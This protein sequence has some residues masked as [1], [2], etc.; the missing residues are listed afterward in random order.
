MSDEEVKPD[1]GSTT[2]WSNDDTR[3][4][5]LLLEKHDGDVDRALAT[6]FRAGNTSYKQANHI[7]GI[8]APLFGITQVEFMN[9]YRAWRRG[10][11]K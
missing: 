7:S 10:Q 2:V 5:K 6:L 8:F 11:I 1:Y 3:N 4:V 9:K